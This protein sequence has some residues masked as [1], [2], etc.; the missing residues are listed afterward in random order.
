[1]GDH[2]ISSATARSVHHA[3]LETLQGVCSFKGCSCFLSE[4]NKV[5][6]VRGSFCWE[7]AFARPHS[8]FFT[9][10][11]PLVHCNMCTSKNEGV[12]SGVLLFSVGIHQTAVFVNRLH[13]LARGQC[14]LVLVSS[15]V[16]S[17][18]HWLGI[19]AHAAL[20]FWAPTLLQ[21]SGSDWRWPLWARTRQI[22]TT[23]IPRKLCC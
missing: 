9:M 6:G 17:A 14:P 10:L 5:G 4:S 7:F 19:H 21:V 22:Q 13:M 8:I 16:Q 2:H 20:V 12:Q 3:C 15:R 11:S 18:S 1:M 23:S